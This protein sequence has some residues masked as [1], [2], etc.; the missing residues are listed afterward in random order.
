[1]LFNWFNHLGVQKKM[2]ISNLLIIIVP[3]VVLITSLAMVWGVIR[4]TNPVAH[5]QWMM[6][7]PSTIQSQ[8]FQLGLEQ[9]N[10]KLSTESTSINDI[11]DSSA[12]LEAQGLNIVILEDNQVAYSTSG[13]DVDG[14]LKNFDSTIN[15]SE[16]VHYLNWQGNQFTYVNSYGTGLTIYGYGQI[17]FMAKSMGPE[18]MDKKLV[19]GAFG[20]G[21]VVMLAII[22]GIGIYISNRLA[23]YILRPVKD[24]K[25]AADNLKDGIDPKIITVRTYDELGDTC[26]AFNNMQ[27]TLLKAREEQAVY[28]ERRREMIAGICHDISTPLTSVKGYASGIL[29][30]VANTEEKRAKYVQR[31][32]DMAGRIEHLVT[33][34]SDFSK[35]E[36]KQIHYDR[37]IYVLDD[38]L[39]EYVASRHLDEHEHIHLYETYDAGDGMIAIDREQF[40]RVLDNLVSNSLKYRNSDSVAIDIAT[41]R[42]TEGY[43]VRFSDDG[44]GVS[45]EELHRLFDIF[46]RTDEARTE[47]ANGNG[48]GLAIVKQIVEDMNGVI[49][50]EHNESGTG[51]SIV[52]EFPRIKE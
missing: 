26:E 47:V 45:T 41:T 31:I 38:L 7:A 28:E 11:L 48:I 39:R 49:Y 2:I 8:V 9:I 40:Y 27:S 30:G 3:F 12:I 29:E 24:L 22:V 16:P 15:L 1:M 13:L 5:R 17:P 34:L 50:A 42:T 43:R 4:Y 32:Y 35:L 20:F 51:L 6:L 18:S 33:M 25:A 37:H 44:R 23:R 46:F 52:M 36:L 21:I 14:L 19:E 10:K